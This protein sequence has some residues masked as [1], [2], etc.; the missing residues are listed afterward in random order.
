MP[1]RLRKE[2]SQK[3]MEALRRR[4]PLTILGPG[5]SDKQRKDLTNTIRSLELLEDHMKKDKTD[6]KKEG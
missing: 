4:L 2:M 3:Q 6:Q 1:R 5:S